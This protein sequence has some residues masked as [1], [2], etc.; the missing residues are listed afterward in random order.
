[1]RARDLR[2]MAL[3]VLLLS[4][5]VS[6]SAQE[7]P[8]ARKMTLD[9]ALAYARTNQLRIV[10]ARQ[11]LTA[12]RR[13][14]EV[15]SAQWLPRVGAFGEVIGSTTNNSTTTLL[16]VSTVDTPRI[17]AT[18]IRGTPEWQP[19]ASTGVGLGVRQQIYDFGRIAAEGAAAS[20]AADIEKY[21]AEGAALDVD[22][23]V[24][25]AYYA[26]LA[27]IAIEEASRNAFERASKYRDQARANV[28]SGLRPPI[29][30]T[31]A[32]ADVARYEAGMT[33]ARGSLHVART[34]LA[35]SVGVPDL[36]LDVAGQ[37][38][39]PGP[40]PSLAD[41]AS[42]GE[43]APEI[44][45][46]RARLDAQRAVTRSLQAQKRPNIW[47]TAAFSTRA[48]GASA[49]AGPT[50]FGEGWLPVVPNYHVGVVL[51]WTIL[52]PIWDRRAEASRDREAALETDARV[53]SLARRTTV[54]SAWHEANVAARSLSALERG[55]D[56]A[57]ANYDQ[58]E[59][60]IRVGLGT[61]TEL[62]DAQ[63]LRT[64]A[65]IQLAIGRFQVSRTRAV[66]GRAVAEVR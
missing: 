2:S 23:A 57:R 61:A 11:R 47:A 43:R 10:A 45:E 28:A 5:A 49:T 58:A 17:G 9:D 18:P 16:S 59:N 54:V 30:L 7:E 66:L 38:P 55:A 33:R 15:P 56:A 62:A 21:R 13:D 25:H 4:A 37:P 51:S 48:G 53:A 36:E 27:A 40:L 65:D 63:A 41:S 31:R 6:A 44:L 8:A 3:G 39:D 52:E 26:V 12:A 42:R 60:R 50:P 32:E 14:A 46:S 20:L 22:F 19:Y 35:A 1:M 34:V 24:E 29:E 64:E